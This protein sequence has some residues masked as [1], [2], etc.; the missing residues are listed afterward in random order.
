M[1][2]RQ[3]KRTVVIV[4]GLVLWI[5]GTVAAWLLQEIEYLRIDSPDGQ[6]QAIVTY[7]RYEAFRPAFAGQSGDKAGFIRIEDGDGRNYGRI[8][9]PMVWMSRD[10]EWTKGGA[11][12]PLV[13]EWD[14]AKGE[15][16][17]WNES[18]TEEIVKRLK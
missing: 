5:V 3:R 12:L 17:F 4:G 18:Q 8:G 2:P 14:F 1:K 10:L 15:Y 11:D 16:R 13:C 9:I 7:R 6:Y